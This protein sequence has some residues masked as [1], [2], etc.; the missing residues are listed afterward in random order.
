MRELAT[1][2]FPGLSKSAIACPPWNGLRAGWQK[3]PVMMPFREAAR[4][5]Q[6]PGYAGPADR[7]AAEVLSKY[8]VTDMY[9]KA[10]QGMP[11]GEAVKWAHDEIVS[12]HA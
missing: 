6:F 2:I 7:K 10:L 4:A 11:A 1:S 12:V 9:A 5:G 8:V 3:D